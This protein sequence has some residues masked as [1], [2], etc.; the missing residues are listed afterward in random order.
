MPVAMV[1]MAERGHADEVHYQPQ[2]TDDEEL[3]QP[4]RLPTLKDP[5]EGLNHDLHTNEPVP[6]V[7]GFEPSILA[8][9]SRLH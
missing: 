6:D 9:N 7:S 1:V 3:C 2:T 5:F 8:R 4:L